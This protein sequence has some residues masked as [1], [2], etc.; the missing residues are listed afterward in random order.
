MNRTALI[1]RTYESDVS[2]SV[3][4]VQALCA[5]EDVTPTEMYFTVGTYQVTVDTSR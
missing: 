5:L 2:P 4:V 3:A 1:D